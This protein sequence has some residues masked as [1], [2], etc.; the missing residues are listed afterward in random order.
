MGRYV[1]P[2]ICCAF[3]TAIVHGKFSTE[4]FEV[5]FRENVLTAA[6][7]LHGLAAEELSLQALD[8]C[9][10]HYQELITVRVVKPERMQE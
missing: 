8:H 5:Q 3:G 6:A 1:V 7:L 2:V 4:S 9:D 10:P